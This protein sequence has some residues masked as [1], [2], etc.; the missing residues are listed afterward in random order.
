[1]SAHGARLVE[2]YFVRIDP[3]FRASR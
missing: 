2:P 3:W 1:M